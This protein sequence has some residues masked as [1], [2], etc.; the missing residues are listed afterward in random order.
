MLLPVQDEAF[1]ARPALLV[2]PDLLGR[3]LQLGTVSGLIV[4]TEAYEPDDPASHSFRGPTPGN[5]AMFGPPG[6]IYVYRSYGMHWCFN[7]VCLPGSAVLVRALEPIKG[8]DLME[9]RRGM[10]NPRL[11]CAGPGRL[12]QALGIDGSHNGQPLSQPPFHLGGETWPSE[13]I[14]GQRIGISKAIDL[15]WRFGVAG[16]RFL[17]K[18]FKKT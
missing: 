7:I 3:E 17:S 10:S 15:Q 2:A 13:I 4:E 5:L 8:V 11:L 1:F 18:P 9:Q 6:Q 14:A 16:S 12:S